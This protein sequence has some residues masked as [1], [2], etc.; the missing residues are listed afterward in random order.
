MLRKQRSPGNSY[1]LW[2]L[3]DMRKF[4][5]LGNS[6]GN[7]Q[8][9]CDID[10]TYLETT[11]E[12]WVKM[13]RIA[14]EDAEDK[15]TV[16][17][18]SD[19]LMAGRWGNL[20]AP[21]ADEQDMGNYPRPLHFVSSSP[22]QL[23]A[24]LEEKLSLDGLDW[25]SDTFK[26]QAYNLKKGR[27]DL[28]KHQVAYKTAAILKLMESQDDGISYFLIGDNAESDPFIYMG[29]KLLTEE[30]LSPQSFESY[31]ELLGVEASVSHTLW[32]GIKRIPKCKIEA[33]FIRNLSAY[34]YFGESP[35]T[36]PICLF[37][38]FFDVNL[39]FLL[40]DLIDFEVFWDVTKSL[41]NKHGISL[42]EIT[43]KI[44]ECLNTD[45]APGV[46]K[47]L[48]NIIGKYPDLE[49]SENP[50]GGIKKVCLKN[51]NALS[52]EDIMQHAKNWMTKAIINKKSNK[53]SKE[54]P[55]P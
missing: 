10:K 55:K 44:S 19:V 31:L 17:G 29:I 20:N 30:R 52:E 7:I 2:Q 26:N 40:H 46:K 48:E 35:L 36:D 38:S 53:R 8:I 9:I 32:Q 45:L 18:A 37:E 15:V 51:W 42:Y 43:Q 11:F 1:D 25:S 4:E 5:D 50:S 47:N 34:N 14:F 6:S 22:T 24:V 13:A 54:A 21:I 12:S 27:F 49:P 16:S 39:Y 33:I 28:L 41:H 23:R 3:V